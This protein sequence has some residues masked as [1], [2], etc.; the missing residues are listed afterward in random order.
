MNHI[1]RIKKILLAEDDK[2]DRELFSE[3]VAGINAGTVVH[4]AENGREALVI[5]E[6][7]AAEP[8][9]IFLDINMPVMNGW[10]CLKLIKADDRYMHIPVIV[11][12][13]SSHHREKSIAIEMGAVLFFT[14]PDDFYVFRKKLD[15][16]INSED[17]GSLNTHADF[18]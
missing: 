12:S 2:D 5:L 11:Y 15:A 3:A 9:M 6:E 18:N 10:Q 1:T 7:M 4:Y 16:I 17:P 8:D 13:S 14:K